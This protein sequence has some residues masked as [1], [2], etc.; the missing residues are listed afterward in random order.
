[1]RS[2]TKSNKRIR[3]ARL[4]ATTLRPGSLPRA[5]EIK[6]RRRSIDV[7]SGLETSRCPGMGN[8]PLAYTAIVMWRWSG[9]LTFSQPT[10]RG[11]IGG[12]TRLSPVLGRQPSWHSP[13]S[14]RGTTA[15]LIR[16]SS[17][18]LARVWLSGYERLLVGYDDILREAYVRLKESAQR[19]RQATSTRGKSNGTDGNSV[20][21]F[22]SHVVVLNSM[23]VVGSCRDSS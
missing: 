20:V 1:M 19:M 4:R 13:A 16:S 22:V 17:M 14:R 3:P 8:A 2:S 5:K 15:R 18:P 11:R 23:Q 9:S 10:Y 7:P 6:H 21:R 12:D